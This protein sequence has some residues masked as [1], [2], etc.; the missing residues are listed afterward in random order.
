MPIISGAIPRRSE[1]TELNKKKSAPPT[2]KRIRELLLHQKA[3]TTSFVSGFV[4]SARIS[5]PSEFYGR[6]RGFTWTTGAYRVPK[7]QCVGGSVAPRWYWPRVASCLPAYRRLLRAG[8]SSVLLPFSY[9]YLGQKPVLLPR[10]KLNSK[11]NLS[12]Y[13]G[14]KPVRAH[15]LL[16]PF[17]DRLATV[18]GLRWGGGG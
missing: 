6:L 7:A 5:L 14:Q 8:V 13:L 2:L 10:S 1:L 17:N 9:S 15:L 16:V 4:L 12:S 3:H 11:K 18:T